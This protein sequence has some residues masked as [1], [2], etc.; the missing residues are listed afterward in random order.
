MSF[1]SV[2]GYITEQELTAIP[3]QSALSVAADATTSLT[4]TPTGNPADAYDQAGTVTPS[5]S[6]PTTNG[7]LHP[8]LPSNI[9]S[10]PLSLYSNTLQVSP[11][12]TGAPAR[13]FPMPSTPSYTVVAGS[14]GS[15]SA[16]DGAATDGQAVTVTPGGTASPPFSLVPVQIYVVN[17]SQSNS[18]VSPAILTASTSNAAG[19]GS[20]TNCPTTGSGVMPTLQLGTTTATWTV[21]HRLH[22]SPGRRNEHGKNPRRPQRQQ[23]VLV[24]RQTPTSPPNAGGQHSTFAMRNVHGAK[25]IGGGT[26]SH[27]A[28]LLA[29]CSSSCATSIAKVSS[30]LN[31]STSGATVTLSTT[32]T[33]NTTCASTPGTP[34]GTVTFK[35]GSTTIGTDNSL[36]SGAASI[37][38]STLAVGTHLISASFASQTTS[39]WGNSSTSSNLSQVVNTASTTTTVL[40]SSNPATYGTS[41]V[42]TATV[43]CA[44][45]G[46]GTPTGTVTFKNGAVAISTCTNV[47]LSSGSATC[48]LSTPNVGSYSLT[49]AYTPT[50]NYGSSTSGTLTQ[51]VNTASTTTT[52]SSAPNP[53]AYG[54]SAL[55]TA[56]VS[57]SASGCGTPTGTVTFKNN[58]T[59]ITGCVS[60]TVTSG[61]ATCTL[62]GLNGG[63]Y[64]ISAAYT[65]TT[66]YGSSTS[67]TI[68][69]SVTAASTTTALTSSANPSTY[70]SS[71]TLTA[72]V[73][74]TSGAPAVG[75]VTFYDTTTSLGTAT[76]NGSGVA[77]LATAALTIGPH[78]LSAVFTPTNANN[79]GS[80]TS[81]T[82]SDTVNAPGGASYVLVGLPYGVWHLNAT[83]STYNSGAA[84][85]KVVITVTPSGITVTTG[86]TY[87]SLEPVSSTAPIVTVYV[88]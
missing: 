76:L 75:T 81:N 22:G 23:G 47:T 65:A 71:V 55:L 56:T 16:P 32:V 73:T 60:V 12:V 53:N 41:P 69:Q 80:S 6:V 29:T 74:P 2:S 87:V 8:A 86:S 5:Y 66:N 14:C 45:S 78:S 67:A 3:T 10:L 26:T 51:V 38:V 13:V 37:T 85:I 35:E 68:T 64:S 9:N 58:G 19:T 82:L 59:N 72:T 27:P 43:T 62:S 36:T 20:D 18:I 88:K 44:A 84:T 57:C 28:V 4:F 49:A 52:V 21:L 24:S 48:T 46:C 7:G 83:Y 61:T 15:E 33:C 1:G 30:N 42:L 25:G 54:T 39:K 40:S 31:P 50:T 34:Q 63:T 17:T 79:F 11:Y 77:T 70:N